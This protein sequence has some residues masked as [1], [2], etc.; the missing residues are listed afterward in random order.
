MCW[1]WVPQTSIERQTITLSV[2]YLMVFEGHIDVNYLSDVPA[3][4]LII[5]T[6]LF[7]LILS[8]LF[9]NVTAIFFIFRT[10]DKPD[11]LDNFGQSTLTY[12][13]W[14]YFYK[15]SVRVVWHVTSSPVESVSEL[16]NTESSLTEAFVAGKNKN[17][18]FLSL[19]LSF[20]LAAWWSFNFWGI[21]KHAWSF[22]GQR[23]WKWSWS[24][25]AFF[26]RKVQLSV[27][28]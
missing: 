18:S 3:K 25:C 14:L 5:K 1:R 6:A 21:E 11:L 16:C 13:H 27:R 4:A 7:L 23:G 24:S 20:S 26:R 17:Y 12:F 10:I 8:S 28:H 22:S 15:L 19:S 9:R 2:L